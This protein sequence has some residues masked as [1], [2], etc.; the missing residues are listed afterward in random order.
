MHTEDWKNK[1]DKIWYRAEI[2][3]Y[4]ADTLIVIK[5]LFSQELTHAKE[6]GRV[7]EVT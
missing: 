6:A 5:S 2:P 3:E 4:A 7:E 1:L